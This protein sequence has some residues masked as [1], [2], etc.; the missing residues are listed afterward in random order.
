MYVTIQILHLKSH[1]ASGLQ[2]KDHAGLKVI[3]PLDGSRANDSMVKNARDVISINRVQMNVRVFVL[4]IHQ[5][6]PNDDAVMLTTSES[7]SHDSIRVIHPINHA[8]E[9]P[10]T[11]VRLNRVRALVKVIHLSVLSENETTL[12]AIQDQVASI[13]AINPISPFDVNRKKD[14]LRSAHS[15]EVMIPIAVQDQLASIRAINPTNPFDVN[16]KKENL[17]SAH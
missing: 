13:R 15:G 2:M 8:A 17:R 14:N 7:Q 1:V 10:I 12:S 3:H 9:I 5:T 6:D 11:F 16:R 4:K